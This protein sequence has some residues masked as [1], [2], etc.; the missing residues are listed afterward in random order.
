MT[1]V[2]HPTPG[3]L[4]AP[5]L[6]D[7]EPM[8][9]L[10]WIREQGMVLQSARGPLAN[11]AEWIAGEPIRGSWW[12]HKAGRQIFAEIGRVLGSTDVVATRLVNGKI[13]LIH[14][15]LWP[16][17]VRAAD[18]FPPERL[19]AVDEEHTATGAHRTKE[20]PFPYW[21]PTEAQ[22]VAASLTIEEALAQLPPCLRSTPR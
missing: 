2:W 22:R 11:V 16:A 7:F 4:A 10:Q 21:V 19:A 5:G 8:D 9:T 15:R 3:P 18:L 1:S 12:G 6:L 17:L 13:T 14:R 20:T